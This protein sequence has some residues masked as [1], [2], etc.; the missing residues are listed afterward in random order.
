[1][2][3]V[4]AVL[5]LVVSFADGPL[6]PRY[7]ALGGPFDLRGLGGLLL[8]ANQVALALTTLTVIVAATTPPRTIEAFGVRLRDQ[9][10]LDGL[11]GELLGVVEDT[12][13]LTRVTLWLRQP[14][15]PVTS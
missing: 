10:D 3:A 11:R 7:L 14:Q 4:P 12:M 8:V 9:V 1:M 5:V 15:A 2:A 6:D 13:Q